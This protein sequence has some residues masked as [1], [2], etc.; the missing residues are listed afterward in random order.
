MWGRQ[1]AA[2]LALFT[3][4]GVAPE[5]NLRE[6]VT[7]MPPQSLNKAEPTLALKPSGD[8][9]R[10]PNQGYQ[11]PHKWTHVQQ[12]FFKKKKVKEVYQIVEKQILYV[13]DLNSRTV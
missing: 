2:I 5:V 4:K 3:S 6:H 11:W 9:T 12:I 8:I 13:K 7:C 1:L 10:S